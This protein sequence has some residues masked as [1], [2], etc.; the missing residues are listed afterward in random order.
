M[1]LSLINNRSVRELSNKELISLHRRIHQLM[2]LKNKQSNDLKK[3]HNI[4]VIE[5]KRRKFQHYSDLKHGDK[6]RWQT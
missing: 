4:I 5:M 6:T 3:I 1:Q 2:S